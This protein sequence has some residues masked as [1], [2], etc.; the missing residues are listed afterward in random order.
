MKATPHYALNI[1]SLINLIVPSA[2]VNKV[3]IKIPRRLWRLDE[4]FLRGSKLGFSLKEN[5]NLLP[6]KNPLFEPV[7]G[8]SW[9]CYY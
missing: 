4:G 8:R 2:V 6:L 9:R 3:L 5:P 1:L 7:N